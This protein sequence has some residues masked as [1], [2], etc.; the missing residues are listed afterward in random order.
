MPQDKLEQLMLNRPV[1]VT[2]EVQYPKQGVSNLGDDILRG[3][4]VGTGIEEQQPGDPAGA[5]GA[6]GAVSAITPKM[7]RTLGSALI[8][9]LKATRRLE[10]PTPLNLKTMQSAD[11]SVPISDE[12]MEAL[13][14]A[15]KRWPR[16][17]GHLD[18]IQYLPL[19]YADED[20][21]VRAGVTAGMRR[22]WDEKGLPTNTSSKMFIAPERASNKDEAFNTVGH[23]LLHVADNLR[24]GHEGVVTSVMV[25]GLPSGYSGGS[26]EVRARLQGARTMA[27]GK[28]L[29]RKDID[30]YATIVRS[31]NGDE[32]VGQGFDIIRPIDSRIS[33]L[34]PEAPIQ[35]PKPGE[36]NQ[37]KLLRLIQE[38]MDRKQQGLPPNPRVPKPRR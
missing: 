19:K 14:F 13:E 36:T 25:G 33:G 29:N 3:I 1:Q 38:R 7:A 22:K 28:G 34:P 26:H 17:F 35:T 18:D 11:A 4:A 8:D 12:F 30:P 37:Q 15:Q 20:G 9:K 16:L 31:P 27:Y 23:E 10:V 32:R 2:G 24:K 6:L 5:I 21:Y